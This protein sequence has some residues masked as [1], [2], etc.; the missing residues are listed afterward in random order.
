VNWTLE[1]VVVP[2]ADIGE[3]QVM[4]AN[5]RPVPHPLDNVGFPFFD[6]PD[7]NSGAVQQISSR[8]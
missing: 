6:D 5:P 4:G 2:V 3:V 1:V 8:A 7:G